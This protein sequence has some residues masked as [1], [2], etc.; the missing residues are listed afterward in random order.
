MVLRTPRNS[1]NYDQALLTIS[2]LLLVKKTLHEE[3]LLR[4]CPYIA[5]VHTGRVVVTLDEMAADYI[6]APIRR[7]KRTPKGNRQIGKTRRVIKNI[8][9]VLH[10][11]CMPSTGLLYYT[12]I[13]LGILSRR[14]RD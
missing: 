5:L 4:G 8:V 1:S 12:D 11:V 6:Y 10:Q 13:L 3:G 9:A 14:S 7:K 2:G